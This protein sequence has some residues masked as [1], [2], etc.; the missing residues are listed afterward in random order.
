VFAAP[1]LQILSKDLLARV[2]SGLGLALVATPVAGILAFVDIGDA[3]SAA[4]G[5]VLAGASA[6]AQRTTKGKPRDDVGHGT[7]AT[8]EDGKKSAG[9]R[10][11]QKKKF[12]GIF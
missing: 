12:L 11:S 8:A 1:A 6:S 3:K 4:C 5:P 10:K 2:G 7:T 9:E